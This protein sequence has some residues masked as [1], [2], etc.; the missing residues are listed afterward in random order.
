MTRGPI[1]YLSPGCFD[2]GGISRYNRYQIRC[3]RELTGAPVE[4][5]SVL[6]PGSDAFEDS[7]E[8]RYFAGGTRRRDK[9]GF[10]GVAL[11]TAIGLRPRLVVIG[12]VNL[13]GVGHL[14]ARAAGAR[15]C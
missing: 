11:R 12:H 6:G 3:L 4:V 2:K 8:V 15:A 10:L 1:L 9:A 5:L 14:I 13:S 7:L